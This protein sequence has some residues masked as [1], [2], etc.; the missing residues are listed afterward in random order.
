M[1]S[2]TSATSKKREGNSKIIISNTLNISQKKKDYNEQFP[3]SKPLQLIIKEIVGNS[4]SLEEISITIEP[5]K[6]NKGI[7]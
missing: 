7:I 6:N 5:N 4:K 2:C 1:G 3:F